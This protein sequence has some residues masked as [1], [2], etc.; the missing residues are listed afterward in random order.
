MSNGLYLQKLALFQRLG[1]LS[2]EMTSLSAKQLFNDDQALTTLQKLMQEREQVMAAIDKVNSQ[3][4]SDESIV[5]DRKTESLLQSE[6]GT[7]EKH[8]ENIEKTVKA[9]LADLKEE[10]K[11]LR[12]GKQSHRAYAGRGTSAEGS[13]IDKRR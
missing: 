13:F 3:I 9:V 2:R 6:A 10:A 1:G 12:E 4:E 5:P 8:N 7:I 11:K